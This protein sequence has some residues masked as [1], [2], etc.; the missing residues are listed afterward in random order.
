M[1]KAGGGCLYPFSLSRVCLEAQPLLQ[2]SFVFLWHVTINDAPTLGPN[3]ASCHQGYQVLTELTSH[4]GIG[5]IPSCQ[6]TGIASQFSACYK[7]AAWDRSENMSFCHLQAEYQQKQVSPPIC[8]FTASCKRLTWIC[9]FT[10]WCTLCA[11]CTSLPAVCLLPSHT[12]A[13]THK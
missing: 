5:D 1:L 12:P 3:S 10:A 13:K 2:P 9:I 8:R 7:S 6:G 4:V 11:P